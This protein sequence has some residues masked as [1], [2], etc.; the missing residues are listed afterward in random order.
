MLRGMKTTSAVP[1]VASEPVVTGKPI[2]NTIAVA[3]VGSVATLP[4]YNL[5]HR[6]GDIMVDNN[7]LVLVRG[8]SAIIDITPIDEDTKEPIRLGA[9]D[10]VLF[11]I[12]TPMGTHKLQKT[13]TSAD[14]SDEQDN[15]LNCII[16]PDDTIEWGVGEYLYDCLLVTSGGVA[17]TFISSTIYIANALGDINDLEV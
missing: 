5:N 11:T 9:G 3:S 13:L 7:A 2:G 4:T 8:N 14:Y 10:K 6:K 12:K 15:S 16:Y 1:T 17:V